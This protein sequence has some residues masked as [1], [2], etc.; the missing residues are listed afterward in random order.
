MRVV[1]CENASMTAVYAKFTDS[2]VAILRVFGLY[3]TKNWYRQNIRNVKM[4]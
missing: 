2:G 3:E 4:Y 1:L